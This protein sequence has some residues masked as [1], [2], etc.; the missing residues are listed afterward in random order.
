MDYTAYNAQIWDD[1][2]ECLTDK[3]SCISHKA[4]LAAKRGELN[5]TLAGVEPV[6]ADWFPEL[7]GSEV[8]CLACGGGQ[9]GPVFAAHGAEVT[10]T[11]LSD[12]QLAKE[13][14]VARREGY[15]IRL[16]KA[17]LAKPLPFADASFDMIFNP[18]S[19]CYIREL[20]PLWKECA[21]VMKKG[22][23][24]MMAF[25]KE[26]HFLFEP[27][28]QK[29]DTLIARHP[30]PFDPL[31]DLT[32]EQREEKRRQR[33]PLAFSHTLTEQLGGLLAAGFTMTALFEDRDGGGLFDKYMD[34]YVAVRAVKA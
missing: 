13:Q 20:Q 32:E 27:D 16:V 5:V 23:V 11:D 8:L 18:V 24:L 29:E 34:S 1:I 2:N 7:K 28:F 17:D 30:L 10:V 22:G 9:Q 25:V 14:Y 19:N 3:A 15:E 12:G 6:P 4:Y 26:E 21:R 31:T 33:L